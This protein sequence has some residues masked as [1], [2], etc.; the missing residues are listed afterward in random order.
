[1]KNYRYELAKQRKK[2][3][4]THRYFQ[5]FTEY[6]DLLETEKGGETLDPGKMAIR[7]NVSQYEQK[8]QHFYSTALSGEHRDRLEKEFDP[9]NAYAF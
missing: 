6:L 9:M 4:E 3:I 2:E 1:M 8:L 7:A 5:L